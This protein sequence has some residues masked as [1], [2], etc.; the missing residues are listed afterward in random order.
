M[1]FDRTV[2][3]AAFG[4]GVLEFKKRKNKLSLVLH[5]YKLFAAELLKLCCQTPL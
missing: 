4:E 5:S 1:W 2:E 3:S